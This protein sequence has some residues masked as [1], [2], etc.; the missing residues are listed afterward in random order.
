MWAYFGWTKKKIPLLLKIL[1]PTEEI[2]LKSDFGNW[3][4]SQHGF[5]QDGV[6]REE[7]EH[8]DLEN[9]NQ[10]WKHSI[11]PRSNLDEEQK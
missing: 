2:L 11:Y 7:D 4:Y 9:R 8:I 1:W 5:M 3:L 10:C 6:E